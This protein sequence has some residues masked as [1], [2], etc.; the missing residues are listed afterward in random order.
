MIRIGILG[1]IGSGKS[2]VAREFGYPVFNADVE[3]NKLYKKNKIIY[4]KLNKRLPKYI[5]SF[6]IDKKQVSNAILTNKNNLKK[7]IKIVHLEIRKKLNIFLKKNK[8]KKFVILDIPLLL[9]N[10]IN[11]KKDILIFVQSNKNDIYKRLKKRN[12]FNLKL[13]NLFKSIK[14]SLSYKK[15]KSKFIIKN[16]FIETAVKKEIKDILKKIL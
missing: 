16:N 6:P 14:Y 7:I 15:K 4:K 2:Y 10:K 8:N 12:N 13:L 1:D 9:E 3:V 11:E 5:H